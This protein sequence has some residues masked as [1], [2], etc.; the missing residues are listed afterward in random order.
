[1]Y[2]LEC[3]DIPKLFFTLHHVG[4]CCTNVA[5]GYCCAESHSYTNEIRDL[6]QHCVPTVTFL[7]IVQQ[8]VTTMGPRVPIMQVAYPRRKITTDR[9]TRG[10]A[11][12]LA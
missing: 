6:V 9:Q 5:R 4:H 2:S 7:P 12:A 8:F 1:V 10:R 3:F 11:H